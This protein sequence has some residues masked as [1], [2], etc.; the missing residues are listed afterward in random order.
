MDTYGFE[1]GRG[2][3]NAYREHPELGKPKHS[4]FVLGSGPGRFVTFEKGLIQWTGWKK[5][6]GDQDETAVIKLKEPGGDTGAS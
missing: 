2:I 5:V 4:Q 6:E 3:E 1:L